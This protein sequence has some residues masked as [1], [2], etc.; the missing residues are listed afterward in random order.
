MV[1]SYQHDVIMY[2][3]FS[4]CTKLMHLFTAP[5]HH[6]CNNAVAVV[7]RMLTADVL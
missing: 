4:P 7:A 5:R 3:L 1:E 2:N 6:H